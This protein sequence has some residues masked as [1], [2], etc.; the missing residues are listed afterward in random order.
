MLYE[1][2]QYSRD[3]PVGYLAVHCGATS[4]G[5]EGGGTPVCRTPGT[6]PP[7]HPQLAG[8]LVA[9]Q[10]GLRLAEVGV[11]IAEQTSVISVDH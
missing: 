8:A 7:T 11:A 5:M 4:P 6:A 2:L 3:G 1:A 10:H 9:T